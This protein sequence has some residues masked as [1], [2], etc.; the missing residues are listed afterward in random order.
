MEIISSEKIGGVI[1][2]YADP[3]RVFNSIK[4]L[5]DNGIN[6]V[7]Y[8]GQLRPLNPELSQ[9][10]AQAAK[11]ILRFTI[12]KL[13]NQKIPLSAGKNFGSATTG[14]VIPESDIDIQLEFTSITDMEEAEKV[15][16]FNCEF[17]D[18]LWTMPSSIIVPVVEYS[19]GV[20]SAYKEQPDEKWIPKAHNNVKIPNPSI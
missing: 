4:S 16:R 20:P 5:Q 12:E 9:K 13:A 8:N 19:L 10:F 2:I 11:D 15:L 14:L 6:Q 3:D 1:V 18:K 7:E 17:R